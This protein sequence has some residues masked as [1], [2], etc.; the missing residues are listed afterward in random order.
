MRGRALNQIVTDDQG[1]HAARV[2][3]V[4]ETR[5]YME[6]EALADCAMVPIQD[7]RE[8]THLLYRADYISLLNLQ[9]T[10]QHNPGTA[11]YLWSTSYVKER[12]LS[13]NDEVIKQRRNPLEE[14][15]D[16]N[17]ASPGFSRASSRYTLSS[18]SNLSVLL[19]PGKK[20]R[21]KDK[22]SRSLSPFLSRKIPRCRSPRVK[23]TEMHIGP[24][25][26]SR[27]RRKICP[28]YLLHLLC[29]MQILLL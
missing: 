7:A 29:R 3:A 13:S 4:L 6:S 19:Q 23:E 14:L 28:Y 21:R 12:N 18:E 5:G 22:K 2:C 11:I 17:S 15:S 9:L 25:I 20:K 26:D 10:K 8:I 1:Q 16:S 24:V 27:V